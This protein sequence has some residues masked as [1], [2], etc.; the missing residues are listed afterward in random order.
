VEGSVEDGDMRDVGKRL[1][2][3][4]DRGERRLVVEGS[5]RTQPLDCP[6]DVVVDRSRLDEPGTAVDDPVADRLGPDE[7]VD[8]FSAI[9]VDQVELQARG[10]GVDR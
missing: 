6:D 5:E 4:R 3:G 2:R 7:A 9:A 10:A 8:R 1:A